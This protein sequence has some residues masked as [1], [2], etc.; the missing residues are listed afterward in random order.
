MADG[1][2]LPFNPWEYLPHTHLSIS[3]KELEL[4]LLYLRT[5][6][7]LSLWGQ[8]EV[9]VGIKHFTLEIRNSHVV[10]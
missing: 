7:S 8:V 3:T 2:E 10:D 4:F 1:Q 5:F 9:D 6:Y